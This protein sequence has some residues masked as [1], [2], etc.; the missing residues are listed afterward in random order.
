MLGAVRASA[1]AA[2]NATTAEMRNRH[3]V[4]QFD[5]TEGQLGHG[6]RV[7]TDRA[8]H[9]RHDRRPCSQHIRCSAARRLLP[10]VLGA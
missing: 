5:R 3:I 10:P 1:P 9:A 2:T 8:P 7:L 4:G 6:G